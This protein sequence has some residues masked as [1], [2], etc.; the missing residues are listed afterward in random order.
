MNDTMTV[1]RRGLGRGLD[2]LLGP[3]V[4]AAPKP[5]ESSAPGRVAVDLIERSRF[6]PRAEI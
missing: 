5:S 6:Q 2:A 4:T 1:K 3:A